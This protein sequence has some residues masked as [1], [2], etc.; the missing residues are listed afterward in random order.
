MEKKDPSKRT[1]NPVPTCTWPQCQ[2]TVVCTVNSGEPRRDHRSWVTAVSTWSLLKAQHRRTARE[3]HVRLSPRHLR[4]S[5]RAPPRPFRPQG[6]T[7]VTPPFALLYSQYKGMKRY[8]S[9]YWSNL[10]KIT[11][12]NLTYYHILF[13]PL[14][15]SNSTLVIWYSPFIKP[16]FWVIERLH[17]VELNWASTMLHLCQLCQLNYAQSY[18][19]FYCKKK[20]LP[21][22]MS[23]FPHFFWPDELSRA[24]NV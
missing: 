9:N 20:G 19:L 21:S 4:V 14:S 3:V 1:R 6:V 10:T 16:T 13:F 2:Y 23:A 11:Q 8:W 15:F 22:K 17:H 5:E 12:L 24:W 7:M 18:W